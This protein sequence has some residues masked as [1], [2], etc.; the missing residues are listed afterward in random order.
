[1][2][3]GVKRVGVRLIVERITYFPLRSSPMQQTDKVVI[4]HYQVPVFNTLV[5]LGPLLHQYGIPFY[6]ILHCGIIQ[7]EFVI[8][9]L[10]IIIHG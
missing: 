4:K 2:T 6:T 5:A 8:I 7:Q 10:L 3:T 9:L 1:M